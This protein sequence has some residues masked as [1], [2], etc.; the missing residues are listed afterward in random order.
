MESRKIIG[1]V[2]VTTLL[3]TPAFALET[4]VSGFMNLRG[5]SDN[6]SAGN[7]YIGTLE[8]NPQTESMTDQRFRM[9]LKGRVNENLSFTYYGE[10][11]MQWGDASY[12][13]K[14]NDGGAI[15]GDTVN[16]ETKNLYMDIHVPKYD[17]AL[18]LGL[19]GFGDNYDATLFSTDMAGIKYYGNFEGFELTAG[20]FKLQEGNFKLTDD[21]TLWGLQTGGTPSD[22]LK[23]GA[24]Y[25]YYQNKGNRGYATFV[26]TADID[27]LTG[28]GTW[29]ANREAMDLHYLG[30]HGS[31]DFGSMNV[32]GWV[33]F[34]VGTVENINNNVSNP[35]LTQDL[36][37]QGY[38]GRLNLTGKF[39]DLKLRL[40]AMYFSGDDDVSDGD[41]TFIVTPTSTEAFAFADDGFM[42]F[43]PDQEWNSIGQPGFAMTDAAWAGYG[44]ASVVL[45]ADYTPSSVPE[46]RFN[47]GV[48][49]FSSLEDKLA[50]NDPRT[51]RAGTQLGSEFFLRVHYM[52]A[53]NLDA[54]LAGSY[55]VLGDFYDKN[56]GGTAV[57]DAISNLENPWEVYLKCTL[58]F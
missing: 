37:V 28:D 22:K 21:V 18:H 23:L 52:F 26:G 7:N 38:A 16:L 35:A 5:I 3:A 8:D 44:L 34:N 2:A 20:S 25:Y 10:V 30:G 43:L 57:N 50:A 49:Y 54:S 55:A 29:T 11:D 31:Y 24:D 15:G 12:T 6:F 9:K 27:A 17:S 13:T 47:T 33:N 19:Q 40:G 32:S 1:I 48:G 4:K 56:G 39:S 41:A 14:R 51:D 53:D 42:V 45:T 46:L 36:D 58:S